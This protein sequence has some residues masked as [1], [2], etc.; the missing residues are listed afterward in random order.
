M[1]KSILWL[2]RAGWPRWEIVDAIKLLALCHWSSLSVEQAHGSWAVLRRFHPTCFWT[3]LVVRAFCHMLRALVV[4]IKVGRELKTL[5]ERLRT[6]RSKVPERMHG[7]NVLV[8]DTSRA[9]D[10]ALADSTGG[11][12]FHLQSQLTAQAMRAWPPFPRCH[13]CHVHCTRGRGQDCKATST[14]RGRPQDEGADLPA[15]E[16]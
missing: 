7:A 8:Q 1:T 2:L 5:R 16:N 11:D 9:A 13:A 4:P 6:L 3:T 14:G 10:V 15:G 12:R